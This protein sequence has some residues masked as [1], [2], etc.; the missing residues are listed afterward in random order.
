MT[1]RFQNLLIIDSKYIKV[2]SASLDHKQEN[3]M[4]DSPINW[5][6]SQLQAI[7]WEINTNFIY[8]KP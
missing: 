7:G 1:V 8:T 5:F 2:R 6:K 3:E 4:N